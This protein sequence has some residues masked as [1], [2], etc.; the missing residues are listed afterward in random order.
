MALFLKNLILDLL[1]PPVCIGCQREI[2]TADYLC[3]ACFKKLKFYSGDTNL[4]LEFI[5][6]LSI[7]GDYD[8][9]RLAELIKL[10]KFKA[11]PEASR[12]LIKWLTLFWQGINALR[13]QSLL[14]L[15]RPLLIPIPL[16]KKRQRERGFNQAE[17]LARGLAQNFAYEL[18]LELIKIK[19]TKAQSGLNARKRVSNL[20]DAFKWSGQI[21]LNRDVLLI[22][23]VITT[24]ATISEAAKVLKMAGAKKISALV[25]A[26]G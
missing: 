26:K 17:I 16:S 5:D 21:P 23:D 19:N 3:I 10:L 22:D 18:S 11:I 4:N 2:K 12:P 13:L 20:T 25:V 15:P 8:D 24:G 1:F 6:E 7:A 14:E 9:R